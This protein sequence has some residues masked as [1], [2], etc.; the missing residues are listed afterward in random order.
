[1]NRTRGD[2][3]A[4][5]ESGGRIGVI[6]RM[7]L[8]CVVLLA[9]RLIVLQV[10]R[11][12]ELAEKSRDLRMRQE[13]VPARRGD[14]LDR[15][16]EVLARNQTVFELYADGHHLNDY[17]LAVASLSRVLGRPGAEIRREH[18][19]EQLLAH[20]RDHV[21]RALK[22]LLGELCDE[23]TVTAVR[24]ADSGVI[25]VARHL[26]APERDRIETGLEAA[27]VRGLYFR[28]TQRRSYPS[29]RR[30][31]H[32]LGYL[33]ASG[34]A[35]EGIEATMDAELRGQD[36]QRWIERDNRG[37]EIA[38]FRQEITPCRDGLTVQLTID[39]GLQ[40]I[41]ENLL[42]AAMPKLQA[43]K[44]S[45]ILQ[46][47]R[48]GSILA[49]ANRPSFDLT[50]RRGGLRNIAVSDRYEPGS[51]FKIVVA[52]AALDLSLAD[53][54]SEVFCHYGELREP[55]VRIRDIGQYGN[56]S[57]AGILAKSSN[58]GIY[59]IA[60]RLSSDQLY[61]Y[62]EDFGFGTRT[63]IPLTAETSG[64]I[65]PPEEWTAASL[66]RIAMGY[67]VS[68]SA[69]QMVNAMSAVANGGELWR[70]R[71][72][73]ALRQAHDTSIREL[74]PESMGRVL[75]PQSAGALADML[76]GATGPS[77]SGHRA[78]VPGYQVAGKTGTAELYS[79][80]AKG[81]VTGSVIA[82]FAGFLPASSPRLCGIVV[83]HDPSVAPADRFGGALAAP[84]FAEIARRA[85]AY[86]SLLPDEA[87]HK[88]ATADEP[89]PLN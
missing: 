2:V 88:S 42:D 4:G 18:T 13:A 50:T 69:L 64:A 9:S 6:R 29:P 82:S 74:P 68:V 86:L 67:E 79:E 24:D 16:G 81:Y 45:V 87:K 75:S 61:D 34:K 26:E 56:L 78:A 11:H 48:D 49:L 28:E 60:R 62:I 32:V 39:M 76:T 30:L 89:A 80:Q 22:A 5:P 66:S 35:R 55:G 72:V 3:P 83:I 36:G 25:T 12:T 44:V 37:R 23:E 47:P 21:A 38:A 14:I 71:L 59:K 41:V 84:L 27:S 53:P 43:A 70:P 40:C 77:G 8:V 73:A 20:Y 31:G 58:V 57:L 7:V 1:M 46:D 63:G 85:A 51:T 17:N 19:R 33:D 52:G 54:E 15:H 10:I 65:H